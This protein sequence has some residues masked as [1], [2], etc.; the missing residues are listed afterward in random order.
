MIY[1]E[2]HLWVGSSRVSNILNRNSIG[3]YSR[4]VLAFTLST[5]V[6]LLVYD[7]FQLYATY[8]VGMFYGG[9]DG[10][11]SLLVYD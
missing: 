10:G 2:R 4:L 5:F 9:A 11:A 1:T 8:P 3:I 7:L 6:L